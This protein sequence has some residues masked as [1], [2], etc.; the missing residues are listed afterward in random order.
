MNT[1]EVDVTTSSTRAHHSNPGAIFTATADAYVRY[2]PEHPGVLIDYIAETAHVAADDVPVLDLGSG[3]GVIAVRL[4][5]LGIPVIAV[6]PCEEMLAAGRWR[7]ADHGIGNIDWRQGDSSTVS[8]LPL[9]RGTVI[10]DAFHYMPR[11]QVLADLHEITVSGGF[12]AIVVSHALGTPKAW[13]EPILD[14]IR[15]RFLGTHRAAGPDAPFQYLTEDHETVLRRSAFSRVRVLRTDYRLDLTTEELIG[16]QY[17]YAFSSKAVLGELR[18][19]YEQALR[20]ALTA[21]EPSGGFTANLQAA[22][23]IGERP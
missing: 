12:V 6:E 11:D 10:G 9:I 2:R 18:E 21:V 14:R 3:P 15:D 5:E 17:T 4:A 7:A 1:S 23:I 22:V 16:L 8:D 13:W 19:E 20:N